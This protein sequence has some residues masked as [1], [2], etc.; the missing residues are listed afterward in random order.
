LR[1]CGEFDWNLN[2]AVLRKVD[3]DGTKTVEDLR[4][5]HK[6]LQYLTGD[7]LNDAI[8]GSIGR[9]YRSLRTQEK[10]D[11]NLD[12][13]I[14]FFLSVFPESMTVKIENTQVDMVLTI[15]NSARGVGKLSGLSMLTALKHAEHI[16]TIQDHSYLVRRQP[17]SIQSGV[18]LA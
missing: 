8:E 15:L 14:R 13:S 12:L 4:A 1:F 6:E 10:L 11:F 7:A 3:D 5:L 18:D 9:V 2:V 16:R 17:L